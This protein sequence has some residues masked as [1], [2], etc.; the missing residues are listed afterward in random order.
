MLKEINQTNNTEILFK[1]EVQKISTLSR[2]NGQL[3]VQICGTSTDKFDPFVMSGDAVV[4]SVPLGIL[5]A[6]TI[7]FDPPL[8]TRKEE[9]IARLGYGTLNKVALIF[10]KRF[11]DDKVHWINN[12]SSAVP[13][14][15]NI[16]TYTK[17]D[18]AVLIGF[19]AVKSAIELEASSDT[20]IIKQAL[21]GLEP[22]YGKQV[23]VLYACIVDVLS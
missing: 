18:T 6:K 19:V 20:D 2:G 14:L 1:H 7:A 23:T 13:W 21:S 10:S 11:W 16:Q 17:K 8:P 5:K 22:H 3:V 15:L 9:A 12:T 4:V